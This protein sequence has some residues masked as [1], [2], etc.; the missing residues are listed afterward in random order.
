MALTREGPAAIGKQLASLR[1]T[2]PALPAAPPAL[3][4]MGAA[5][6]V[7]A[8]I[9]WLHEITGQLRAHPF[10]CEAFA[11]LNHAV[12]TVDAKLAEPLPSMFQ[13]LRGFEIVLDDLTLLPPSGS[14]EVLVEGA[15]IADTVH[16]LLAKQPQL[17]LAVLP[18][19]RPIALPLARMGMPPTITSAHFAMRQTRAAITVGDRS[20]ERAS[21]RVGAAGVRAPVLSV[22]YDLPKLRE[23][24]PHYFK[25]NDF[26]RIA[27]AGA[28]ALS[29][30]VGEEGVSIEMAG[31]WKPRALIG[32]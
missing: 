2:M 11:S 24:F 23:K 16:Q 15:H 26:S 19:G 9:A 18:D 5:V 7:D 32:R 22:M 30:D 14:G 31:T 20:A 29:L 1:T 28:T 6:D 21:T 17:A 12:D 27:A 10:R 13:G 3:F 4:A 25:E 8:T